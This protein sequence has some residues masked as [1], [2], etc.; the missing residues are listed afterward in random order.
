[1]KQMN[2]RGIALFAALVIL[3]ACHETALGAEA[4]PL[5]KIK[6]ELFVMSQCPYGVNAE[7]ALLPLIKKYGNR[8]DFSLYFIAQNEEMKKETERT[9][10]P[11][12]TGGGGCSGS[13]GKGVGPFYSLHGQP[14][15][16]EDLRQVAMARHFPK[17]YLD[18]ILCRA[19]N[20][21]DDKGWEKCAA[22]VGIDTD[23]VKELTAAKETADL[24]DTNI[25]K[26]SG[27]GIGSSPTILI[28]GRRYNGYVETMAFNR[29]LCGWR[30]D[31][32]D[33]KSVPVCGNDD[34]CFTPGKEAICLNP[35][36]PQAQCQAAEPARFTV[37]IL[38]S[39]KCTSCDTAPFR[40]ITTRY[41]P[42]VSY[43]QVDLDSPEGKGM[44]DKYKVEM[45]PAMFFSRDVEKSIRWSRVK[46]ALLDKGDV[47]LMAPKG[48][49]STFPISKAK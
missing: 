17:K 20:Y 23:K 10:A 43:R 31:F 25:Q 11:V 2:H 45:L 33:C 22:E 24:F 38:T 26:A 8:F 21:K 34:D 32:P 46:G 3:L 1:M 14:E 36:K 44:A 27:L 47:Y 9:G 37:T 28:D 18:Y 35:N 49:N 13:P 7:K 30:P 6:V 40:D 48:S 4:G 12:G 15:V 39:M 5:R 19:G 16:D 42:K 29:Y 41:F